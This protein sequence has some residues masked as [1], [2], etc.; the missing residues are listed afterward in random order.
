MPAVIDATD[1]G[2]LQVVGVIYRPGAM[3]PATLAAAPDLLHTAA[4]NV[5]ASALWVRATV[6]TELTGVARWPI[7]AAAN[8]RYAQVYKPRPPHALYAFDV[9]SLIFA[10]ISA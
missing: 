10:K 7:P 1:I 2:P 6:I 8:F 9:V 4:G 5:L 3:E